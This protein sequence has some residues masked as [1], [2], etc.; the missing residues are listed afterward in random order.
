VTR[1]QTIPPYIISPDPSDSQIHVGSSVHSTAG[2]GTGT[3]MT[4]A[5]TDVL[6]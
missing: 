4:E 1:D 5:R 6:G 3:F 2:Q